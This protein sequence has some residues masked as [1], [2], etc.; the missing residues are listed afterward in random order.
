M[1]AKAVNCL[2]LIY[3]PGCKGFGNILNLK[4]YSSPP[5]VGFSEAVAFLYR[6]LLEIPLLFLLIYGTKIAK[7][8][9][10]DDTSFNIYAGIWK[11][12]ATI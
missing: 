8:T 7:I 12:S 10:T 11:R 5:S 3:G 4:H 1:E 6:T 2:L 9:M